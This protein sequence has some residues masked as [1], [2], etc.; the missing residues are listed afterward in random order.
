MFAL[1][2]EQGGNGI[3]HQI[4]K[5]VLNIVTA[6][7]KNKQKTKGA[8]CIKPLTTTEVPWKDEEEY[9]VTVGK[10]KRVSPRGPH[11]PGTR[12]RVVWLVWGFTC[13]HLKSLKS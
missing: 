11:I 12:R 2:E 10:S 9:I 13:D 1:T 5:N 8:A 6:K 3:L 7:L 4:K